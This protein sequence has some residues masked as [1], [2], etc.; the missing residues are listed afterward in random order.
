[1]QFDINKTI[2]GTRSFNWSNALYLPKWK[3]HVIP[4]KEQENEIIKLAYKLQQ[5]RDYFGMPI[6]VT[7]W[8]RPPLYNELIGG[9]KNSLHTLGCAVDFTVDNVHC[10]EVRGRLVKMLD[11]L[12]IRMENKPQSNW[13][14]IDLGTPGKTGRFFL[15]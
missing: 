13:V 7:S 14:H 6:N 4:T 10:D 11:D 9:A 2:T 5:I 1:M 15:P 8:L 3:V 12:K